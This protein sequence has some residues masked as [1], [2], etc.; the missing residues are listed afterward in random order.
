MTEILFPSYLHCQHGIAGRE[1]RG[2][3][4]EGT[5]VQP[6]GTDCDGL[7]ALTSTYHCPF[8]PDGWLLGYSD[9]PSLKSTA[10]RESLPSVKALPSVVRKSLRT[11]VEPS[12]PGYQ[13]CFI[14]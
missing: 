10:A 2:D 5:S 9:L 3:T 7:I 14:Q 12:D 8:E 11:P 6:F 13:W 1:A 4:E